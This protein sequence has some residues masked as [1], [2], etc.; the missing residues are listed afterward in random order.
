[1]DTSA[2][3]DVRSRRQHG[4]ER[5]RRRDVVHDVVVVLPWLVVVWLWRRVVVV[6]DVADLSMVAVVLCVLVVLVAALDVAWVIH[7]VRIFRRKGPRTGQPAVT[8]EYASDAA[9]RPVAADW[10]AV[11]A[12]TSVVVD[13]VEDGKTFHDAAGEP[14]PP[15]P[16]APSAARGG[17]DGAVVPTGGGAD[18][19]A[20]DD[21][22]APVP[23]RTARSDT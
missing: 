6:T 13:L 23:S 8:R 16:P 12:A 4:P 5:S 17:D 15:P 14:P 1:M 3:L 9:G 18:D 2:D 10:T 21:D 7:N 11:R 22:H 19:A 20:G